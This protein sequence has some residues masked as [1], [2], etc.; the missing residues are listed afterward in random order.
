MNSSSLALPPIFLSFS[1]STLFGS[2]LIFGTGVLY[3][4]MALGKKYVKFKLGFDFWI[5][6]TNNECMRVCVTN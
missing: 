4:F 1:L 3:G 2:G 6:Q 5:K